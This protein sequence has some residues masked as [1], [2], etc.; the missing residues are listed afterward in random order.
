M[1][2]NWVKCGEQGVPNG[3]KLGQMGQDR[4]KQG[5]TKSNVVKCGKTGPNMGNPGK[6]VSNRATWGDHYWDGG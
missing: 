1:R 2:L 3:A 6:I 5:Q 4:G